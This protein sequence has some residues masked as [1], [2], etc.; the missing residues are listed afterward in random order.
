MQIQYVVMQHEISAGQLVTRS[1][2]YFDLVYDAIDF[3]S[4]MN[5]GHFSWWEI[6]V[7]YED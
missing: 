6:H 5:D 7:V 1:K 4:S 2:Q 3:H